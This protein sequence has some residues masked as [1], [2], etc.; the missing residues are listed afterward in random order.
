MIKLRRLSACK[1]DLDQSERKS[2]QVHASLFDHGFTT[3]PTVH[4]NLQKNGAFKIQKR[5]LNR[6]NLK[7]RLPL[8][9]LKTKKI[10]VTIII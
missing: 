3:R 2:T 1:F 8:F 5:S 9:I 7:T 10:E 6:M 4:S